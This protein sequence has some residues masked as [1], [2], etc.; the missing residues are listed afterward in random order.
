M[1][2][3]L[4]Q[5]QRRS[6][7]R[8]Q[9]RVGRGDRRR[10]GPR[11]PHAARHHAQLRAD[12]RPHAR[13]TRERTGELVAMI[14][15]EVD[16]LD[17]VVTALPSSRRPHELAIEDTL[18]DPILR[19]AVDFV[20]GQGAAQGVTVTAHF[21]PRAS[22]SAT[23]SRSTRSRLNLLV[24]ALQCVPAGGHVAVRTFGPDPGACRLRGRGRRS[25]HRP[26][27]PSEH[28]HPLLHPSERR[29]WPRTRLRRNASCA[30]TAARVA[31]AATLGRGCD[32]PRRA[33]GAEG[34]VKRVLVVDDERKMRR[35]LQIAPRADGPRVHRPPRAREEALDLLRAGEVRSRA[36]RPEA[37]RGWAAST[38]CRA[39]PRARR[40]GAGD[41]AHGLRHRRR[42]RST[43]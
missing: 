32:V 6:R 35:V 34:C 1:A 28:L 5:A 11:D 25:R 2:T 38:C 13:P 31:C 41:R 43:R 27:A 10:P 16:R 8:R 4:R 33:A 20:H 39:A 21:G 17:R 22:R 3:D 23:P 24:N 19:R 26:G 9:A 15:G 40:R 30:R 37:C 42:P 36:D 7:R 12:A 29:H 14:V 18:L